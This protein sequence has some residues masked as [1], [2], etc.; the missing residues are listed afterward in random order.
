MF[1]ILE[2]IGPSALFRKNSAAGTMNYTAL[3]LKLI[4]FRLMLLTLCIWLVDVK[5]VVLSII[6]FLLGCIFH[7]GC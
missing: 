7:V 6:L 3:N 5:F 2:T 1:S 4:P